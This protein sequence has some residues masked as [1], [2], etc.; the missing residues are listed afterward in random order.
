MI[1]KIKSDKEKKQSKMSMKLYYNVD[2]FVYPIPLP[3]H[4]GGAS[5]TND[6]S[7]YTVYVNSRL[8]EYQQRDAVLHEVSH[9]EQGHLDYRRDLPLW[10]KEIEANRYTP[11]L[12]FCC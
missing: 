1:R 11:T 3:R 10:L 9:I 5:T 2:Y 7:T 4:I 8:S 6:D 12:H